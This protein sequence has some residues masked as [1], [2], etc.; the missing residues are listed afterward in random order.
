MVSEMYKRGEK[1]REMLIWDVI[2]TK[3]GKCFVGFINELQWWLLVKE[4]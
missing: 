3:D 4:K 1:I 2:H